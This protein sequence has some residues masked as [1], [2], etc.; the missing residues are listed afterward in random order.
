MIFAKNLQEIMKKII[1]GTSDTWS[2]RQSSHRPSVLYCKLTDL[3]KKNSSLCR[4]KL[5]IFHPFC[6]AFRSSRAR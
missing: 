5:A 1:L 6:L 3:K 2:M 4:K